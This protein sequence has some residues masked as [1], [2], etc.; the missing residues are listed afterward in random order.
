MEILSPAG[1][2]DAGLQHSDPQHSHSQQSQQTEAELARLRAQVT[3]LET[4]RAALWWAL[5]HDELTGLANRRLFYALAPPVLHDRGRRAAV[6]VLD[7]NGFK[8][9]NDRYGHATGDDVLRIVASRLASCAGEDLAAR[10]G[11]DEFAAVLTSPYPAVSD[12]WWQRCAATLSAAIAEPMPIAGHTLTV[13]ASIGIAPAHGDALIGELL[14][15]ADQ[16]M[17]QAKTTRRPHITWGAEA[18]GSAGPT[19]AT[20]DQRREAIT[21]GR[22]VQAATSDGPQVVELAVF[23]APRQ[24]NGGPPP[25]TCDPN[26]R[27]PDEVVPASTYHRGDPVWVHRYGSWRPGVV[28]GASVRAVMATYRCAQGRGTV[29]DTMS[30]EYVM[31]RAD[32]DTQLDRDAA[33]P[34]VAA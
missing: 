7:L 6:I 13:T 30:A 26:G 18:V 27:E 1:R 24:P 28:E 20:R 21:G 32:I 9:I 2:I 31:P 4:E 22:A 19:L 12:G 14:H 34:E 15:Y 8:P 23:P 5:G 11:G 29:V 25:R 10:L 17:Y 3:W 33:Q 16:A